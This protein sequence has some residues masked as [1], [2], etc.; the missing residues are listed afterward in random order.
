MHIKHCWEQRR[1]EGWSTRRLRI[2]RTSKKPREKLNMYTPGWIAEIVPFENPTKRGIPSAAKR[3]SGTLFARRV[4][5]IPFYCCCCCCFWFSL[6]TIF[7]EASTLFSLHNFFSSFVLQ[8]IGDGTE[9]GRGVTCCEALG[10]PAGKGK[11]TFGQDVPSSPTPTM[12][13]YT[14]RLLINSYRNFLK[15]IKDSL[16]VWGTPGSVSLYSI[17][18]CY[19]G[20]PASESETSWQCQG[21]ENWLG[22][23]EEL[24]RNVIR[25]N[26]RKHSLCFFR[27]TS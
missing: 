17:Y 21:I 8:R 20:G 2:S 19:I 7:L 11:N 24:N 3:T 23:M 14:H 22:K 5:F 27:L 16:V 25:K 4:Y 13:V 6:C 10:P 18:I 26:L 12:T 15:I 1:V 9:R